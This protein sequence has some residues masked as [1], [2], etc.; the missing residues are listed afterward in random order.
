MAAPT[1]ATGIAGW[2]RADDI[3]GISNGAAITTWPEASG[4]ASAGTPSSPAATY[5]TNQTVLTQHPDV[6]ARRVGLV[7]TPVAAA[8]H[9]QEPRLLFGIAR[10]QP[11]LL[12]LDDRGDLA[13]DQD[14][15]GRNID[16][17][18]GIPE[19]DH[20]RARGGRDGPVRR[21]GETVELAGADLAGAAA[22]GADVVRFRYAQSKID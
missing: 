2:Y 11:A 16:L 14:A 7:A 9:E 22:A 3:T 18:L 19:P 6:G 5:S 13:V 10:A 21:R 1:A 15:V 4:V 8:A 12:F 17:A 20:V